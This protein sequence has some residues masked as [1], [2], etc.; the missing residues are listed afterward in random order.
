MGGGHWQFALTASDGQR[1][2]RTDDTGPWTGDSLHRLA[3]ST[4]GAGQ[5]SATTTTWPA[6]SAIE[7]PGRT[8]PVTRGY[9]TAT[10]SYDTAGQLARWPPHQQPG[11]LAGRGRQ[12]RRQHLQRIH[13]TCN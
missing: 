7:D 8:G 2:A 10:T 12:R 4:T 13:L 9:G 3:S 6:G 5:P 1:T 11:H